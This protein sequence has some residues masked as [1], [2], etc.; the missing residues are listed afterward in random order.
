MPEQD[1]IITIIDEDNNEHDVI[2]HD[3]LELNGNKYAIVVS[4]EFVSDSEDDAEE[5]D[6]EEFDD[7]EFDEFDDIDSEDAFVLKIIEDAEGEEILVEIDDEEWEEI[8]D[9]CLASLELDD[10]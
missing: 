8:K 7:L 1:E 2:I 6:D 10:E 5:Y 3:I 9:A 4:V